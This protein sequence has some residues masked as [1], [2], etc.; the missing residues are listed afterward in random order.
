MKIDKKYSV[1]EKVWKSGG[2]AAWYFVGIPKNIS[3]EIKFFS[4]D[5]RCGWGSVRVNIKMDN[6]EWQTSVFP[7]SKMGIYLLPL[8]ASVRKK[9]KIQVGDDII[10]TLNLLE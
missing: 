1:S 6:I 4:S 5:S 7:D 2:K 9:E 3:E 8:K 10:F